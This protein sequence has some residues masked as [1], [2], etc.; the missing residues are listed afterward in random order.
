MP[1][2]D[3]GTRLT[4]LLLRLLEY[5]QTEFQQSEVLKQIIKDLESE[6]DRNTDYEPGQN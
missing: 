3:Q 2:D 4:K 6:R 5:A 1:K